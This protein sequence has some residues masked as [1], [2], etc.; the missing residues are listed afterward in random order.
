M[1][2]A[3]VLITAFNKMETDLIAREEELARRNEELFQRIVSE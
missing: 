3:G 2:S 1:K